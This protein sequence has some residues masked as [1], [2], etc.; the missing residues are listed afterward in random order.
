M[1]ALAIPVRSGPVGGVRAARPAPHLR[2]VGPDFVPP[3]AVVGP[4]AR[5]AA[6]P[7]ARPAIRLSARGRVVR[8]ALLLLTSLALAIAGGAWV[9]SVASEAGTYTGPVER[10]SVGAGD[11]LWA[12]AATSA[13]EG[14][15]VRDVV[16]DIMRLND[17]GSGELV[18]GQQIVVPAP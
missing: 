16:D 17:L 12:I 1:S 5:P 15:D 3:V 4:T 14:Q 9:G 2:L 6:G 7:A 10:V 11:T 13:A 18:V 8:G